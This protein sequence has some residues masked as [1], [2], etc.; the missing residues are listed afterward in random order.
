MVE[1]PFAREGI[2][3]FLKSAVD[4]SPK[5]SFQSL[6]NV[7][8]ST[9][10]ELKKVNSVEVFVLTALEGKKRRKVIA[11]YATRRENTQ[12]LT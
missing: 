2:G 3:F 10:L 11:L 12:Y 5:F 1:S 4:R 8:F 9:F 6:G 7:L